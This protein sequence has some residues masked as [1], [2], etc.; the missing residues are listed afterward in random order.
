[1]GETEQMAQMYG[2]FNSASQPPPNRAGVS[3]VPVYPR[4]PGEP[5]RQTLVFANLQIESDYELK[6]PTAYRADSVSDDKFVFSADELKE[7][8]AAL[9]SFGRDTGNEVEFR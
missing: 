7:F 3:S 5:R 2:H 4:L 9:R 6:R 1:M 8:Q